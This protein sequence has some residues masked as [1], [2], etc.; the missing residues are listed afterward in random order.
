[1]TPDDSF[2]GDFRKCDPS[3][4]G[5]SSTV[6]SLRTNRLGAGFRLLLILNILSAYLPGLFWLHNLPGSDGS[7]LFYLYSP[8]AISLL[9]LIGS[10]SLILPT[11]FLGTFFYG[12]TLLSILLQ[13]SRLALFTMPILLFILCLAQGLVFAKVIRGLNAI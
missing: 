9:F 3:V 7:A 11:I 13:R 6:G 2:D 4:T 8:I 12:I 5:S 1:M 10:N